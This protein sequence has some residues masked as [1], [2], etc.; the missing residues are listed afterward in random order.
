MRPAL[1]YYAPRISSSEAALRDY[2]GTKATRGRECKTLGSLNNLANT[3][4][5]AEHHAAKKNSRKFLER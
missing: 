1:A 2:F 4:G 5:T 3:L